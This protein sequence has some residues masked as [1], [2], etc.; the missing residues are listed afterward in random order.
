LQHEF[1][2]TKQQSL[3][4]LAYAP[5]LLL[6]HKLQQQT[7]LQT[8]NRP[9]LTL[10]NVN[11]SQEPNDFGKQDAFDRRLIAHTFLVRN[12]GE[13]PLVLDRAVSSCSCT[14]AF[15]G[16][17]TTSALPLVLKPDA[18]VSLIVSINAKEL[19]PGPISKSVSLYA[20]GQSMPLAVFG[21]TGNLQ[22]A[23]TFIPTVLQV[24]TVFCWISDWSRM[25]RLRILS[26]T[27]PESR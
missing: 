21:I 1:C 20:R 11:P 26:V 5:S 2:I 24:G 3:F 12:A 15:V 14:T 10:N 7:V 4:Y 27:I 6:K 18:Q 13:K 17:G 16:D 22:P 23:A 9:R 8:L 25:E 19:F